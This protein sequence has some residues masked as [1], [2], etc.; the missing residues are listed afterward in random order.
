MRFYDIL[1][2]AASQA[3]VAA[4]PPPANDNGEMDFSLETQSALIALLEDI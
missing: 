4:A 2:A 1:L 3:G